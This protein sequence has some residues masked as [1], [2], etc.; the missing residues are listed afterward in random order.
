MINAFVRFSFTN[1]KLNFT[2]TYHTEFQGSAKMEKPKYNSV[3]D[4]LLCDKYV[5]TDECN[6]G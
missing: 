6:T 5:I 3:G 4:I 2:A 1:S